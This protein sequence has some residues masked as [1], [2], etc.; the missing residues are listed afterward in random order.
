MLTS[1]D[2]DSATCFAALLIGQ[3]TLRTRLRLGVLAALDQRIA[4]RAHIDGMTRQENSQLHQPSPRPRLPRQRT[5]CS[6]TTR[7]P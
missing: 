3:P 5:P 1:Y 2:L 4:L 7:S 6:A